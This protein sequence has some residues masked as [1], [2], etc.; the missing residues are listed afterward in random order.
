MVNLGFDIALF[1]NVQRVSKCNHLWLAYLRELGGGN[2]YVF[3]VW[4]DCISYVITFSYC[5]TQYLHL[6]QKVWGASVT[7]WQL[8]IYSRE[9]IFFIN[10]KLNVSALVNLFG[11]VFDYVFALIN[12]LVTAYCS[13]IQTYSLKT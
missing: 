13:K 1:W 12:L 4:Y 3:D 7:K 8:T 9:M 2:W 6:Y 10:E 5:L 11:Y